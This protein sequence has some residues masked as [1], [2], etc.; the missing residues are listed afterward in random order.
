MKK[1]V[2][3]LSM[4]AFAIIFTTACGNR[5]SNSVEDIETSDAYKQK[6][7]FKLNDQYKSR[8]CIISDNYYMVNDVP[9]VLQLT[10]MEWRE[11][12]GYKQMAYLTLA[13]ASK[14][15]NP[16]NPSFN[17]KMTIVSLMLDGENILINT[18]RPIGNAVNL[19]DYQDAIDLLR[20]LQVTKKATFQV[21][22]NNGELL[23]YTFSP[24]VDKTK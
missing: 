8:A 22:L 17:E 13:D 7:W 21:E 15:D 6:G 23:T 20:R 4:I 18:E 10:V 16:R 3:F 24:Y 19:A 9:V 2:Y 11:S 14:T 5:T 12:D 1:F